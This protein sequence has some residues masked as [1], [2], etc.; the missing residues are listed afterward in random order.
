MAESLHDQ[1]QDDSSIQGFVE[2][3]DDE[4]GAVG[5]ALDLATPSTPLELEL[6]LGDR[7]LARTTT[8]GARPDVD[9][10][11]GVSSSPGF[12]F[13]SAAGAG[14][15]DAL[16]AKRVDDLQVRAAGAQRA[17]PVSGEFRF[18]EVATAAEEAT[19][20]SEFDLLA[21]LAHLR[22]EAKALC[23]RP[24]RPVGQMSVGY[25]EAAAIDEGGLVWVVGWGPREAL[26]DRP[27]AILDS[28]KF[29][30][31]FAYVSV[32]RADLPDH[33]VGIIG[34][35]QS[36]WQ[37]TPSAKS[38]FFISGEDQ[39][40]LET[41]A[42]CKVIPK[43]GL[44]DHCKD[45]WDVAE[46][47]YVHAMKRLM[48]QVRSWE[49]LPEHFISERAVV[50]QVQVVPGFGC[51]A[52]GWAVSPTKEVERLL[53]KIGTTILSAD[54]ALLAVKAR[55]DLAHL[56]P[57]ADQ[58]LER[59]GFSAV[60]PGPIDERAL[61]DATLK[62]VYSDG[63]SS[64]HGIPSGNLRV[65]GKTAKI[66][67]VLDH[68]PAVQ[69]E[70][71]FPDMARAIR[72]NA[73]HRASAL[74]PLVIQSASELIVFAMP[75]RRSDMALLIDDIARR[76]PTLPPETGIALIAASNEHRPVVMRL[77]DELQRGGERP[78]SLAFVE[79][80]GAAAYAL[81]RLLDLVGTD[82]FLFVGDNARL[83]SKGWLAAAKLDGELAFL[84]M[85]DPVL[86]RASEGVPSFSAF[87]WSGSAWRRWLANGSP[88]LGG[89]SMLPPPDTLL[90]HA[91]RI[92][93]ATLMLS[94][95]APTVLQ[96]AINRRVT[97]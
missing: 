15:R 72:R 11:M 74:Q 82:N 40:F 1:Q 67:R 24:L 60:F 85:L 8:S 36:D 70:P 46:G 2:R 39:R 35:L 65:L 69:A 57:G 30:A 43:A 87:C 42:P 64:N 86:D 23:D 90:S 5:W 18:G 63:T 7:L 56:Y 59:A 45:L 22:S 19:G 25:I 21:R 26:S 66:E 52:V 27:A 37:P 13:G 51:L 73:F 16:N 88:L 62:V 41:L 78:F 80:T 50:D 10:Y 75:P 47:A 33:A 12:S 94:T 83:A 96:D 77:F 32:P 44:I 61:G 3:F 29:P 89:P 68:F 34:V 95:I 93:A 6:W 71:F 54:P 17:L 49:P 38:Y 20:G 91:R 84:E 14:V 55:P 53:L 76:L 9:A 4:N 58:M 92:P 79:D 81:P 31:G 48:Q 28:S 97:A